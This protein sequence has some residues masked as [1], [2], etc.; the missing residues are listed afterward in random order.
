MELSASYCLAPKLL[1]QENKLLLSKNKAKKEKNY[2]QSPPTFQAFVRP[3]G[4]VCRL[5][6]LLS[7]NEALAAI[8][9][10]TKKNSLKC[11]KANSKP[12]EAKIMVEVTEK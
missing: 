7:C 11:N 1:L 5:C 8:K 9:N 4:A 10:W 2:H 3:D 12:D 6:K